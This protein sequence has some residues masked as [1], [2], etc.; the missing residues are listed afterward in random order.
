MSSDG[1]PISGIPHAPPSGGAGAGVFDSPDALAINTARME[2]L[3]SLGMTIAG[4]TVLDVGCGVGRLAQ[5]F[6][7]RGCKVVCVDG[8]AENITDLR[9]RYPGLEAHVADVEADPLTR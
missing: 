7:E 2:H 4:R 6:V 5:F 8:R 9:S 1:Y 3:D